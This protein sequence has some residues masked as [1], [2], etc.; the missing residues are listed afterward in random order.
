MTRVGS[1]LASDQRFS[2]RVPL[3]LLIVCCIAEGG[4][5]L[6]NF[7][8]EQ[9]EAENTQIGQFFFVYA[10]VPPLWE[11]EICTL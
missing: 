8:F 1:Q 9:Y 2:E 7:P 10:S 3:Y 11:L 4:D 5:T 6:S